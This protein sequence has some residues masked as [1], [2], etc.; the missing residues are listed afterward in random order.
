MAQGVSACCPHCDWG[1]SAMLEALGDQW[2]SHCT[3]NTHSWACY[4]SVNTYLLMQYT[5]SHTVQAGTSGHSFSFFVTFTHLDFPGCECRNI[6]LNRWFQFNSRPLYLFTLRW[7]DIC[8]RLFSFCHSHCHWC[9]IK[10][11]VFMLHPTA[12]YRLCQ[13]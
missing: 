13:L 9:H 10:L 6:P 5:F 3:V 7:G 1:R 4:Q 12:L 11:T 8:Y 2:T